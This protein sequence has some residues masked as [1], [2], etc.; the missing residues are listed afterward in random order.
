MV[1]PTFAG[2]T[3]G[4]RLLDNYTERTDGVTRTNY[5][6]GA[7]EHNP[8][9]NDYVSY[10]TFGAQRV[11]MRR[12]GVVT[13]L[14]GDHL[15]SASLTTSITGTKVS[16]MRYKPF[17]E[18]RW[19]GTLPTDKTFTGQRA[20]AGLGSLMDYGARMYS[21]VVGRFLSA[22]TVVPEPGRPQSLNRFA[23]TYNNPLKFIDPTGHD[24]GCAGQDAGDCG[25]DLPEVPWGA[26]AQ[27]LTEE[28]KQRALLAYMSL[29]QNP[30]MWAEL[31]ANPDQ[32]DKSWRTL[33]LQVFLWATG[34]SAYSG[35][36]LVYSHLAN[37][38]GVEKAQALNRTR[39]EN[40]EKLG[41]FVTGMSEIVAQIPPDTL[42]GLGIGIASIIAYRGT[43]LRDG[44]GMS[45]NDALD[46]AVTFLGPGY[47]DA[48]N[49]RF[50]SADGT[51][52]VRM[53]D[54]DIGGKHGGGSHMNFEALS[55]DA[56]T[57]RMKVNTNLHVYL[58]DK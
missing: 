50:V 41:G 56:R 47:K 33:D 32:W 21:P 38:Y 31:F 30:E 42:L 48:G 22:D 14:H 3:T 34:L 55:V 24:V 17:G 6:A 49:G 12:D 8:A 57:G 19:A 10:F 27:E 58:T 45:V 11:A 16:E 23:Y 51:R 35:E 25:A 7:F 37:T 26:N 53:G 36:A 15:G 29:V 13:W 40:L 39:V 4:E 46:A 52:V 44:I 20:E 54:S 18:T 9:T 2:M 43:V 1:I 5:V 28:E